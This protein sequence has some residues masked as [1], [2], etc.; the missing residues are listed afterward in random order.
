KGNHCDAG[1]RHQGHRQIRRHSIAKLQERR[2]RHREQR[3]SAFRNR[4]RRD[5]QRRL[6]KHIYD[7]MKLLNQGGFTLIE[8]VVTLAIVGVLAAMLTPVVGKYI[9]EARVTRASDETQTIST[10]I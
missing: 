9:D 3:D 10:A 4:L 7:P 6:A 5:V 1:H 2:Y 8:I